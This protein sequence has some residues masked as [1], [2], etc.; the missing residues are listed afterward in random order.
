VLAEAERPAIH[1]EYQMKTGEWLRAIPGLARGP[2]LYVLGCLVL[3]S[4]LVDILAADLLQALIGLALA[5]VLMTGLIAVPFQWWAMRGR[6]EIFEGRVVVDATA[7]EL[8]TNAGYGQSAIRWSSFRPGGRE[9]RTLF[10]L[11]N[12][13][14]SKLLIPKRAFADADLAAFGKLLRQ[15]NLVR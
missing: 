15:K 4:V 2:L 5:S 11:V 7:D 3:V 10:V 6:R 13:S 14:R 8:R 1:G 9:T 12:P